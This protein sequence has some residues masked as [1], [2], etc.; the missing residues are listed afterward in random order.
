MKAESTAYYESI[1]DLDR[2][3]LIAMLVEEHGV[4]VELETHRAASAK[5]DT[6]A[7]IQYKELEEKY[8]RLLKEFNDLKILYKKE[9]DKNILKVRST[10]GRK[11]EALLSLI[12]SA[13]GKEEEPEDESQTEDMET[14]P[15]G[16][17]VI[18]F[19]GDRKK[20]GGDK[21][22]PVKPRG[23]NKNS[24][25]KSLESLPQ[26]YIYD[27]DPGFLDELYGEGNWNIVLWH[28]HSTVEKIPVSYYARNVY[29]PVISVG[30]ERHLYTLPY[31]NLL[32]HHGHVSPSILAD[33]IYRKFVLS[34]PF[35]R[36]AADYFMQGLHLS[37]QTII[38]WVNTIVP[39]Y[40][41]I[42]WR[43]M[44]SKLVKCGYI[45]SDESF[46]LVNKDGCSPG[47]K[48]YMWVHCTS[49]LY[50]GFPII[51]FC[52]EATRNTD[53]LREMFG[54][55]LGYITCDAYISYQVFEKENGSV[56]VTGCFMHLRRYFAEAFFINDVS[57]LSN[58][59]IIMMPETKVLIIIREIY[60]VENKLKDLSA[61][62]RRIQRQLL[63][64]PIVDRLFEYIHE[65]A[66]D[67]NIYSDRMNKA[68]TYAINQEQR[69]REFLNDGNIPIDNGFSERIIRAYST[70]RASW[71]FADTIDG[72]KVNA[73]VYSI[74][75]TAKANEADVYLYLQY[76]LE[77]IPAKIE[78]DGT[79]DSGFLETMM[80]WSPQYKEYEEHTKRTS[81]ESFRRMFPE[82]ERP[83]ME[84][85]RRSISASCPPLT[86]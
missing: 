56:T 10:F 15:S 19:P 53:H 83:N 5:I 79:C 55:F 45:Q 74:T 41:D 58:E 63:V 67:S 33:I 47:H 42:V 80:P 61:E 82:P 26:E 27:L 31:L 76:L 62:D 13:N 16:K 18:Q 68:I 24:L 1:K 25:K 60:A 50:N 71:L 37:K 54:D 11:T 51:I 40:F 66:T 43:Y 86:A 14:T 6:E 65:L 81:L 73:T 21:K 59:E 85:I 20:S 34:L 8:D 69:L 12:S 48:S 17:R 4:R 7:F 23:K 9:L 36:Q 38:N 30:K 39:E 52:Y 84:L 28:K 77:R 44:I 70:G 2:A 35:Y 72:A 49:E 75:E 22:P 3:T 46:I 29:T 32:M 78:A 64:R 57:T